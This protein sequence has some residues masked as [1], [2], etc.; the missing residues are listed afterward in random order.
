MHTRSRFHGGLHARLQGALPRL[1]AR[2][3]TLM[4]LAAAMPPAAAANLGVT[5]LPAQGDDEP[6]TVYYPT[7]SAA[8]AL[9]HGFYTLH[10]AADGE[11]ARGNGRLVVVSHGTGGGPFVH[12]DL[13]RTLV[14]AGFVVAVPLHKGD[15]WR[16]HRPGRMDS[17]KRRPLEVSRA[18]DAVGRDRRFAPLLQLDQVGVYGMSAGG[19]T[20]LTLAGGRWSPQRFISHCEAHLAE[21]FQFCVGVVTRLTGGWL[22]RLK[23]WVARHE[24]HRRFDDDREVYGHTDPRVAAVVAA[25]PAAAPIDLA[26]LARPAVPLGLVTMGQDRWLKPVF[27]SEAVLA[28]CPGCERVAH[29]EDGGHGAMLSPLPPGLDGV[30]GEML[31][32][33][34]GF[35]RGRLPEVDRRIAGFF[36]RM[37]TSPP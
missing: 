11:A 14:D 15:N 8:G 3:T 7:G 26:T 25:V 12:T 32:D 21:D 13:A 30:L 2:A 24:I 20:A 22:D 27:H 19:F 10:A 17:L 16:D 34:E 4:A 23:L 5:V 36:R 31:N 37:L 1:L 29:L 28:A 6:V 18:I 35:D 9:R 33:P